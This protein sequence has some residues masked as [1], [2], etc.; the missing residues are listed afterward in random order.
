MISFSDEEDETT[1]GSNVLNQLV[2][3]VVM[4]EQMDIEVALEVP[5]SR[6]R[7]DLDDVTVMQVDMV[8]EKTNLEKLTF[9]P[10]DRQQLAERKA[11]ATSVNRPLMVKDNVLK[12]KS[13]RPLVNSAKT[14]GQNV[15]VAFESGTKIGR[16]KRTVGTHNNFQIKVTNLNDDRTFTV[17]DVIGEILDEVVAIIKRRS[18]AQLINCQ[19]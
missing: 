3:K 11:L 1:V 6:G 18:V 2:D 16:S 10:S 4:A 12:Y 13:R 5:N 8:E 17:E 9:A 14:S 19:K 15:Q 7:E